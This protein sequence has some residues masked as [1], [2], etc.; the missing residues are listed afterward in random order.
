MAGGRADTRAPPLS[1]IQTLIA[2]DGKKDEMLRSSVSSSRSW[3][4]ARLVATET[5]G[6]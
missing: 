3:A 5:T 1:R 4:D 6:R 2:H